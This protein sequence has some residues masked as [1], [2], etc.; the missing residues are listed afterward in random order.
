MHFKAIYDSKE[1]DLAVEI[2]IT[3]DYDEPSIRDFLM[4]HQDHRLIIVSEY[5]NESASVLDLINANP[6]SPGL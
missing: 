5:G 6:H 2:K 4:D 1:Y 3:C